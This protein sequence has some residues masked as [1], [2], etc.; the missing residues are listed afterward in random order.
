MELKEQQILVEITPIGLSKLDFSLFNGT[1]PFFG[2]TKDL[3]Y[4][5]KALSD[6]ELINLTTI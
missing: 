2:N 6:A 5:P 3:Q 4:Y 1:Q